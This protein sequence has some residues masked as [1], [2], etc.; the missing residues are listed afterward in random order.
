MPSLALALAGISFSW[1]PLCLSS[2]LALTISLCVTDK[3]LNAA[4]ERDLVTAMGVAL[5]ALNKD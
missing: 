4:F 3:R 2:D 5:R 1:R